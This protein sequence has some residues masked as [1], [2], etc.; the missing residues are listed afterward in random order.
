MIMPFKQ[1][2]TKSLSPH[3]VQSPC[4]RARGCQRVLWVTQQVTQVKMRA[5]VRS[6]AGA[7]QEFVSADHHI[8]QRP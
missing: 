2:Q 7:N 1:K 3:V 4:Q 8:R 6:T 5:C